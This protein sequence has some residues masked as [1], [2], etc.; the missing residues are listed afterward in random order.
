[1]S[2]C[3]AFRTEIDISISDPLNGTYA[4]RL[5][6]KLPPPNPAIQLTTTRF[7]FTFSMTK[8]LPLHL[9]PGF[10]SRS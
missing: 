5:T 2:G 8:T 9:T 4:D 3:E 6:A 1:M 7:M 10:G